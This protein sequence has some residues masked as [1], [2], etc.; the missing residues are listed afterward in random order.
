M[1]TLATGKK[2]WR[3]SIRRASPEAIVR[4]VEHVAGELGAP[5]FVFLTGDVAFSASADKEYPQATEWLDKLLGVLHVGLERVF[6][7][8]G[9]RDVDRKKAREGHADLV[10]DGLRANPDKVNELLESAAK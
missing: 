3:A 9:N 6:V 5:D 7:V 1:S 4:D 10:H 2:R 8:P